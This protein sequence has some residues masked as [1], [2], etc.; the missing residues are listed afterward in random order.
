ML[1]KRSG[2]KGSYMAEFRS[3]SDNVCA[4]N[5]IYHKLGAFKIIGNYANVAIALSFGF[6]TC[7]LFTFVYYGIFQTVLYVVPI[8]PSIY[9]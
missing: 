2:D 5:K 6:V 4:S 3:I 9:L 8:L 7:G 1:T